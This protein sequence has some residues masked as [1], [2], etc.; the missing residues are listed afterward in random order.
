M[1][2]QHQNIEAI[3]AKADV[4]RADGTMFTEAA[5]RQAAD[6]KNTF[7]DEQSRALLYRGPVPPG[8]PAA[9]NTRT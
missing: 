2:L 9:G 6:G 8:P 5:L 3:L 7:W 1:E 4:T